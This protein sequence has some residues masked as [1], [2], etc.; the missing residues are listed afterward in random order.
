MHNQFSQGK[1]TC[2]ARLSCL[3]WSTKRHGKDKGVTKSKAHIV[4]YM[5]L[6]YSTQTTYLEGITES[7]I[8]KPQQILQQVI[9]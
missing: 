8:A 3:F 1:P 2:E 4:H 7:S 9:L 6:E 5:Q